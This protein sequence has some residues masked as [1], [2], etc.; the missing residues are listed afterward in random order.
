NAGSPSLATKSASGAVSV[1]CNRYSSSATTPVRLSIF[2]ARYSAK[3]AT[4]DSSDASGEPTALLASRLN[5]RTKFSAVTGSPFEKRLL[6]RS[7]NVNC[8]ASGRARQESA[9]AGRTTAVAGSYSTK[10]LKMF[11]TI[12][13]S[14][15]SSARTGSSEP[16]SPDSIR[17]EPETGR[18]RGVDVH[19]ARSRK[20][21]SD[22]IAA[23]ERGREPVTW[24]DAS[25]GPSANQDSGGDGV[26][27]RAPKG[28][29]A[30]AFGLVRPG[31]GR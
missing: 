11:R 3:P 16:G 28:P 4:P 8:S 15:S 24:D 26:A 2:A 12:M 30:S 6:R 21:A 10:P 23:G 18:S 7:E 9:E 14:S 27:R 25:G 29:A 5:A 19:E 13:T 1:I 22:A 31:N 17:I 20:K